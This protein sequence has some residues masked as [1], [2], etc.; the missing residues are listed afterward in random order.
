MQSVSTYSINRISKEMVRV[1]L[2]C[3]GDNSYTTTIKGSYDLRRFCD[4][5]YAA[6]AATKQLNDA[7]HF[8]DFTF[9]LY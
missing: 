8:I 7:G 9:S 4:R 3:K 1:N 5:E 6:Q 2:V